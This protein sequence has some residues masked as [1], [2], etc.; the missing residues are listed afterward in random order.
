MR[1]HPRPIP[2]PYGVVRNRRKY[3]RY[4]LPVH[5]RLRWQ[6]TSQCWNGDPIDCAESSAQRQDHPLERKS[7]ISADHS[8][9]RFLRWVLQEIW[10]FYSV[11]GSNWTFWLSSPDSRRGKPIFLP[12]RRPFPFHLNPW[13][14]SGFKAS[15][16]GSPWRSNVRSALV[17]SRR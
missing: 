1:R 17:W 2:R 11:A 14:Y 7:R 6:R 15:S 4:E 3:P 13:Q 9:L 16:R 12:P 8:G 10:K 5:G